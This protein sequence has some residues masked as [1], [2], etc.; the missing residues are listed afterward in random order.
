MARLT[1]PS[2]VSVERIENFVS[3][4]PSLSTTATRVLEICNSPATSPNDLNRVI[5]LDPVLTGQVLK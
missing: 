4:M 1:E 2:D 5:A 3:H